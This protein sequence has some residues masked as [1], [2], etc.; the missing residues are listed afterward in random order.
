MTVELTNKYL[1]IRVKS[2]K[3][4]KKIRTDDIG[5]K[6]HSLRLAGVSKKTGKWET[7][8][9]LVDRKDI[10]SRDIRTLLLLNSI[11]KN[12]SKQKKSLLKSKVR[13]LT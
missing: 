3:K 6:G 7:Q 10:K 13:Q 11:S 9:W 8:A 4:F 5:R 1:R 2:P 12:L